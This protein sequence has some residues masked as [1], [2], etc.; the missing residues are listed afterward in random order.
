MI[1]KE[2]NKWN[3]W[4]AQ[5]TETTCYVCR[6]LNGRIFDK[7]NIIRFPPM[8]PLCRCIVDRLTAVV[9]GTISE[10]GTM[11]A[12]WWL[13]YKKKLPDYYIRKERAISLGWR[14]KK[15]NLSVISPG[16]MIGGER[17]YNFNKKLP[18]KPGRKWYEADIN[19]IMGRRNGE[20]IVYSN[21]NL[22]FY[23]KDHY[24]TFYEVTG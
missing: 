20:R 22:I 10:L 3:V 9:V 12:D 7:T 24:E 17:Y 8:H 14:R 5:L 4:V 1:T 23:T 21:D 15:D 16:K 6:E 19:Y 18:D 13:Y 11:G 2:S